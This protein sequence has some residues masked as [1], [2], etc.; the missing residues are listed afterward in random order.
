MPLS[1]F[2]KWYRAI[3]HRSV[4]GADPPTKNI[5]TQG[6]CGGSYF[7]Q[8]CQEY[9]RLAVYPTHVAVE[10]TA[11]PAPQLTASPMCPANST[12]QANVGTLRDEL[13]TKYRNESLTWDDLYGF[14]IALLPLYPADELRARR[15]SLKDRFYQTA[16]KHSIDS[17]EKTQPP[18]LAGDTQYAAALADAI[19]LQGEMSNIET[20]RPHQEFKRNRITFDL[21]TS[22]LL[23]LLLYFL[24]GCSVAF[25]WHCPFPCIVVAIMLGALGAVVSSQRR[26]QASFDEDSSI[27]NTTRYVGS[28]LGTRSTPVLGSIFGGILILL[29]YSGLFSTAANLVIPAGG[30]AVATPLPTPTSS[31]VASVAQVDGTKQLQP[32]QN[33][34]DDGGQPNQSPG[35]VGSKQ[36]LVDKKDA[37]TSDNG[38]SL[39]EFLERG[40]T[41]A[42]R[43]VEYAKILIYAF[44]AGFAERLVPDTLDRLSMNSRRD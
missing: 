43:L 15:A 27:L 35:L 29:I 21:F 8:A 22:L 9:A 36:N 19:F 34:S 41:G 11:T 1:L 23:V 32:E 44:L 14:Q 18:P 37:M 4:I 17:Y 33:G 13:L 5:L 20:Y 16:P 38:R 2:W 24:I 7:Q 30:Q 12:Y 26:L 31:P 40:P 25:F 42:N 28:G 6:S 39:L 3:V 10:G